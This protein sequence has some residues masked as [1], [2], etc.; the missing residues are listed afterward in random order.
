MVV[1]RNFSKRFHQDNLTPKYAKETDDMNRRPRRFNGSAGFQPVTHR[2][3][4][5]LC[6][7]MNAL[8]SK[9]RRARR[10]YFVHASFV[11]AES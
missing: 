5:V 7:L 3:P 11:F 4:E 8:I 1:P 9:V 6:Q 10:H 2:P